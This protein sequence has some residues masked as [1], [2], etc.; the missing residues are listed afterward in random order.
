MMVY[1]SIFRIWNGVEPPPH[2]P[3]DCSGEMKHWTIDR[4]EGVHIF[5]CD[6]CDVFV[7]WYP[8]FLAHGA[9]HLNVIPIARA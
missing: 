6:S 9:D 7:T 3:C 5:R 1:V 4:F 2:C 8:D